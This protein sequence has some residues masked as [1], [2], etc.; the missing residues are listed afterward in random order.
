M[1]QIARL[2]TENTCNVVHNACIEKKRKNCPRQKKESS[3]MEGLPA[4]RSTWRFEKRTDVKANEAASQASGAGTLFDLKRPAVYLNTNGQ[5]IY[6]GKSNNFRTRWH[7]HMGQ[8]AKGG[9]TTKKMRNKSPENFLWLIAVAEGFRTNGEAYMFEYRC[10]KFMKK[11]AK[12]AK[13]EPKLQRNVEIACASAPRRLRTK[14]HPT[15]AAGYAQIFLECLG[16]NRWTKAAPLAVKRPITVHW[17][18]PSFRPTLPNS[19]TC[20][21]LPPHVTERVASVE[22]KKRVYYLRPRENGEQ[23]KPV[24][25]RR[26]RKPRQPRATSSKKGKPATKKPRCKTVATSAAS[27]APPK[28]SRK[29]PVIVLD[30]SDAESDAEEDDDDGEGEE[31]ESDEDT[32]DSTADTRRER[33]APPCPSESDCANL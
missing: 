14:S 26:R 1:R 5:T 16:I 19:A 15:V 8:K 17:F 22:D 32:D 2:V 7:Q 24:A 21:Y 10:H 12:D 4:D 29:T 6:V 11:L 33:D 25:P 3:Q 31:E 23:N 30:D 27:K 18:D 13:F 9:G 20:P 28:R